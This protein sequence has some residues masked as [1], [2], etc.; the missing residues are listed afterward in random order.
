M[1]KIR[2]K[3]DVQFKI[4][5]CEVIRGGL[6]TVT[7]ACREYQM[8]EPRRNRVCPRLFRL[9]ELDVLEVPRIPDGFVDQKE[10]CVLN[11]IETAYRRTSW[12]ENR[13]E[14]GKREV[15]FL[16]MMEVT[17]VRAKNY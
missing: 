8:P 11:L 17:V 15:L 9:I 10:D 4:K 12:N 16:D 2:R 5:I 7:E 1:G 14:F 13:G 3:F 6:V